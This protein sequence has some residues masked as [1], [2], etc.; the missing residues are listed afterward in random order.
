M[1]RN[2]NF[3]WILLCLAAFLMLLVSKAKSQSYYIEASKLKKYIGKTPDLTQFKYDKMGRTL[4]I[5]TPLE[6]D[7]I[8]TISYT[9]DAVGNRTSKVILLFYKDKEDKEKLIV[10]T[11]LDRESFTKVFQTICDELGRVEQEK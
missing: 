5:I 2:T 7:S 10:D 4:L 9:Y 1:K 8:N 6:S 3:L 11:K